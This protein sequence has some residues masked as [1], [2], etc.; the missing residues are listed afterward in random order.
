MKNKYQKNLLVKKEWSNKQLENPKI[1]KINKNNKI[2]KELIL[3]FQWVLVKNNLNIN[4]ICKLFPNSN[5]KKMQKKNNVLKHKKAH[6]KVV[7]N[8][9]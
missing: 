7:N 8:I 6:K 3:I 4:K 2:R 1:Y 5:I 9:S